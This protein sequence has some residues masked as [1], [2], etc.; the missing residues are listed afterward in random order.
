MKTV[1]IVCLE[2]A[3]HAVSMRISSASHGGR[4][5]GVRRGCFALPPHCT[6]FRIN[7]TYLTLL[8]SKP[9][10]YNDNLHSNIQAPDVLITLL[11]LIY[12]LKYFLTI[13]IINV[14]FIIN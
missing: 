10:D 4:R 9:A 13:V 8:R 3:I 14:D 5:P 12:M 1:H 6:H 7:S 11:S 2:D